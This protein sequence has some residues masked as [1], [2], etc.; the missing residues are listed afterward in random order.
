L[1]AP[2]AKPLADPKNSKDAGVALGGETRP[3]RAT[4][5]CCLLDDGLESCECAR[6]APREPARA[7]HLHWAADRAKIRVVDIEIESKWRRSHHL[8][9]H[10]GRTSKLG[11]TA[12]QAVVLRAIRVNLPCTTGVASHE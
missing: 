6:T 11:A 3:V 2:G 9:P 8:D 7:S 4:V 12:I 1:T 10:L 5:L